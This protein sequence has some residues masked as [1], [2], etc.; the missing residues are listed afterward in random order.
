M[1]NVACAC[2]WQCG[3]RVWDAHPWRGPLP[4]PVRRPAGV[5][6]AGRQQG[7]RPPQGQGQDQAQETLEPGGQPRLQVLT[8]TL[9]TIT[10]VLLVFTHIDRYDIDYRTIMSSRTEVKGPILLVFFTEN[11]H[12]FKV[13]ICQGTPSQGSDVSFMSYYSV[14]GIFEHKGSIYIYPSHTVFE[15]DTPM[16][17]FHAVYLRECTISWTAVP[18]IPW[19]SCRRWCTCTTC[20]P[21]SCGRRSRP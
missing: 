14:Y 11:S 19:W 5:A 1:P 18:L 21:T 10:R 20:W 8:D 15:C 9:L 2:G 12:L 3:P 4:D 7:H 6:A 17:W 16:F 13:Y